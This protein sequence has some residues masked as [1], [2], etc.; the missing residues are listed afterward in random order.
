MLK[1][2]VPRIATNDLWPMF[3]VA[4]IGAVIA[5]VYGIAHDQITYTISAEYFTK[6]KFRQFH[7]ADFGLG[8]RVF[9][10]T[11]GFLATWWVGLV[12]GWFLARRM[13]PNQDL[14]VAHRKIAVG[15][16]I[17]VCSAV[18]FGA[19]GFAYGLWRGPD[20]DYSAW[21]QSFRQFAIDDIW[22]FVRVAWIHNASYL[23]G[24]VGLILA[25]LAIHPEPNGPDRDS[26]IQQETSAT[27]Q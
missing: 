21:E 18:L 27:G 11:I 20:V 23:G 17:L 24:L 16:G 25:L 4:I 10:A 22:S 5:G 12:A 9:V 13:I 3:R 19:A 15:T 14:S 6:L 8:E 7:Y 2:L 26:G 1:Y